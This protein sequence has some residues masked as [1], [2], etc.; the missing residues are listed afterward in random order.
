MIEISEEIHCVMPFYYE[1]I[2]TLHKHAE[3]YVNCM[4]KEWLVRYHSGNLDVKNAIRSGRPVRGKV[5][6]IIMQMVE[7]NRHSSCQ[8][9]VEALNII[10]MK[11]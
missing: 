6:E 7:Q 9:I 8:E 10:H 2:K 11:V 4:V 3:K 5:D 1:K